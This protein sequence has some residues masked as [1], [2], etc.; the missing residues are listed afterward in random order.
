MNPNKTT[1]IAASNVTN[2]EKKVIRISRRPI[3]ELPSSTKNFQEG[4]SQ[5]CLIGL[6]TPPTLI[7]DAHLPRASLPAPY[8]LEEISG[9]SF[10][11]SGKLRVGGY[12]TETRL[13]SSKQMTVDG[14]FGRLWG[15]G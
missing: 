4:L 11:I 10:L 6:R 5:R 2:N 9:R 7:R 8:D 14:V 15:F 12:S 3:Q 13:L 1:I